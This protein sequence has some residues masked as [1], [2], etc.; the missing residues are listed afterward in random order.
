MKQLSLL[1]LLV[2]TLSSQ[3]QNV[4][5]GI[6]TPAFK[7]DVLSTIIPVARFTGPS[8]MYISLFENNLYRGYIGS[9]A[10]AD[11][12]VDFGTGVGNA[13]GKVHLTI[14]G[15]PKLT[16]AASGAVDV[17]DE[18]TRSSKTGNA[19]LLAIAYANIN[20]TGFVQTGSGNISVSH[21]STGFYDITITG[22]NY[23][24]QQ[25]I[26][27]VTPIGSTTPVISTTG[28]GAG[29]LQVFLY[30]VAGASIDGNFHFVIY[31]P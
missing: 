15:I 4:G 18:L 20:S 2:I 11:E 3:A 24:F 13:T 21:P 22:E 28:S 1:L 16:V 17:Q 8:G 6:P 12:D 31:K 7:L 23:H 26:T 10:G 30:N 19:N 9:W 14:Q 27:V 5:I 29:R 25:Y